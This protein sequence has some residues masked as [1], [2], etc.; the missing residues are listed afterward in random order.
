MS[1]KKDLEAIK[2]KFKA[3]EKIVVSAFQMERFLK[4]YK[5]VLA[6]VVV[7]IVAGFVGMKI[8]SML[9]EHRAKEASSLYDEMVKKGDFSQE[10]MQK[11]AKKAPEL[12]EFLR[13]QKAVKSADESELEALSKSQN[14]FISS[15]ARYQNAVLKKDINLLGKVDSG[16]ANLAKFEQAFLLIEQSEP[17]KAKEILGAVS[18]DSNIKELANLLAHYGVKEAG[19]DST[20]AP[21]SDAESKPV[22]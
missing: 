2:E 4:R 13:L 15:F 18:E 12:E 16:F 9:Q 10:A 7:L 1:I 21:S 20:K 17:Q 8:Q 5:W 3:D 11:L 14:S 19:T 22:N 6:G